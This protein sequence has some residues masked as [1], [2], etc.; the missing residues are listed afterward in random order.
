M[1]VSARYLAK[2]L[3]VSAR[4]IGRFNAQ[5]YLY[6]L[7]DKS[8]AL[9]PS[10][11]DLLK[12]LMQREKWAFAQLRKFRIFNERTGDIFEPRRSRHG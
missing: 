12:Y 5:G 4:T 7:Q 2:F 3:G 8:F 11:K 10:V 6:Q 1:N 9:Q